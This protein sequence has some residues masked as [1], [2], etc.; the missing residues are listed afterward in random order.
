VIVP[1]GVNLKFQGGSFAVTSGKTLTINGTF[2]DPGPI[3]IFSGAG[4]VAL[5]SLAQAN[6]VRPEWWG[7]DTAALLSAIAACTTWIRLSQPAYTL[8]AALGTLGV[9]MR[10]AGK[11]VTTLT[12]AFNGDVATLATGVHIEDLTIQGAGATYTGRGLV[13]NTGTGQQAVNRARIIDMDGP[14]LDFT[15][16]D[17]GSQFQSAQCEMWRTAAA[18]GTGRYA[19]NIFDAA[20]VAAHPRK[21]TQLETSGTCAFS[22][23]GCNDLYISDSTV[24][25][26]LFS[27]NSRSVHM[28]TSRWLNQPACTVYGANHTIAGNDIYPQLTMG[29]AAN[30]NAIGDN[31]Y[32]QLPVID[33]SSAQNLITHFQVPFTPTLTSGGTAPSLGN[34]TLTGYYSR[35]GNIVNVN[36]SLTLGSTTALGTGGLSFSLPTPRICWRYRDRRG[37]HNPFW[38]CLCWCVRDRWGSR[39]DVVAPRHQPD[40]SPSTLPPRL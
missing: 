24:G 20:N 34:G 17:A 33:S 3:K 32:N 21:W 31:S 23:G 4:T 30:T 25:D 5:G 36:V 11:Y 16:T 28:S 29:A 22:F 18:T 9:S 7:T 1:A 6:G 40:R 37:L 39:H 14:C 35:A 8:T 38:H 19:I 12:K 2:P 15:A 26:L 10:G 27:V 13:L